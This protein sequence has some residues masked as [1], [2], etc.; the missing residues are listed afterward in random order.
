M[1]N[2]NPFGAFAE[3]IASG[4]RGGTESY[5][6]LAVA[7]INKEQERD[8]AT[9]Q[10]SAKLFSDKKL[11]ANVRATA[12]KQWQKINQKWNTGL[13][14][15]DIPMEAWDNK[16]LQS[17]LKRAY[18]VISDDKYDLPLKLQA[19][20]GLEAEAAMVLEEEESKQVIKGLDV[21]EEQIGG[22]ALVLGTGMLTKDEMTPGTRGLLA[23]SPTGRDIMKTRIS[24][25]DKEKFGIGVKP[26]YKVLEGNLYA[27]KGEE[28]KMIKK[29]SIREQAYRRAIK[30]PE[31]QYAIDDEDLQ[32]DLIDK[33]ER[34]IKNERKEPP[35]EEPK[36]VIG[37]K[38]TA[39]ENT[40]IKDKATGER[41]ITKNGV[42]VEYKEVIPPVEVTP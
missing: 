9:A 31:W 29:G 21:L 2:P 34:M 39:P 28:V 12:Y 15:P 16:S 27:V 6:G 3:G 14:T 20:H 30:D 38:S 40:I 24:A 33:H 26:T 13:Q 7:R 1:P 37:K 5:A 23:L 10:M 11:P 19:L 36:S 18:D 17:Y 4:I 42:W 41:L 32:F 25:R 8:I 22:E 35:K